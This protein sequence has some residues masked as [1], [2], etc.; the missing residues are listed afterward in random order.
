MK[1]K[2]FFVLILSFVLA[3]SCET[4]NNENEEKTLF[5]ASK[6]I[7]CI[8]VIPQQ[9]LLVK[10]KDKEDWEYFYSTIS[11]FNYEEGFEYVIVV[12][13]EKVNNPIEDSSSSKYSLIKIESKI[14]KTSKN[15]PN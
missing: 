1:T 8:G 11:G 4:M 7:N 12:L 15:L 5:I 2:V 14:K 10:T 13:E 3:F 6:T 9:C